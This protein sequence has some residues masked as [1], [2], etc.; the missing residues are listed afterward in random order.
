MLEFGL[1]TGSMNVPEGMV[2]ITAA[3]GPEKA[4][5]DAPNPEFFADANPTAAATL[6]TYEP[7]TCT[8]LFPYGLVNT[9]GNFDTGIAISNPSGFGSSPL[10]GAITFTLF[11]NGADAE[12][13]MVV[14]TD[15]MTAGALNDEGM[16]EA[17][18]TYTVLLSEVLAMP[19][20]DHT[21]DFTGHF[22]AKADFT[23]CRGVGWVTD[24]STVNQAYLAYFGDNLDEG[25]VP[26]NNTQ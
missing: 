20:A 23:G 6:F 26:A 11:M 13:P 25:G 24:F 17:G 4:A 18:N 7:A 9:M 15:A 16:L 22:Y 12:M 8:L 1:H 5:D 3:F 2:T 10:N 14:T 21:G 19:G